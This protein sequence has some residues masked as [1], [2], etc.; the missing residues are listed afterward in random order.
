MENFGYYIN[1]LNYNQ[2][3]DFYVLHWHS[4]RI[5]LP[6]TS[7]LLAS[8][9]ICD[10]QMFCFG[11]KMYGIQFHLEIVENDYMNWINADYE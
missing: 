10:E 8:S 7:K 9:D 3:S 2:I 6:K 1:L 4:D 11:S 5:L